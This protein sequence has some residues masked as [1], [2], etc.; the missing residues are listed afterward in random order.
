MKRLIVLALL[1][2]PMPTMAQTPQSAPKP[3]TLSA[4]EFQA[5]IDALV[6]ANPVLALLLRKQ[7]E[8]QRS[9]MKDTEAPKK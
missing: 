2:A 3:I 6:E 7:N 8:A 9:A 4:Q 5:V 1:C